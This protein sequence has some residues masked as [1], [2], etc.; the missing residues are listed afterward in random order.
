[1]K[2]VFFDRDGTLIVDKNYLSRIDQIELIPE[3][4][5]LCMA[6]SKAGYK[7]F[8]VS[9]QSGVARGMFDEAKVQ[10][11]NSYLQKMLAA[12]GVV[13][14]KC[15]YCPHHQR[16]GNNPIYTKDCTCRKPH[17][18]MLQQAAKEF[19]IDLSRSIMIGDKESDVQAGNAV[20]CKS[21]LVQSIA[22][23]P[24]GWLKEINNNLD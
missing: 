13:I 16:V 15:F 23:D 1:M 7:F 5:P 4:L 20:G 19:S 24:S 8:I 17:P 22:K 12:H 18:G 10:E 3:M 21:F 2:A 11:V 6:L 9:N 14:E